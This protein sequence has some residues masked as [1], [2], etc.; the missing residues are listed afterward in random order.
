LTLLRQ[1]WVELG[2]YDFHGTEREFRARKHPSFNA[3][4]FHAHKCTVK[5]LK[6][7]LQEAVLAFPKSHSLPMLLNLACSVEPLWAALSSQTNRLNVYAVAFRYP[8]S[9]ATKPDA[10]QALTDCRL[11]RREARLSLGLTV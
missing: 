6:A 4:W 1:E 11:V 9:N 2:E 10:K 8:G 7:R 5:Y 3:A